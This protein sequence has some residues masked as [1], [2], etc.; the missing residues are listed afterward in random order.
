[1]VS[2]KTI[3]NVIYYVSI[4]VFIIF[5]IFIVKLPLACAACDED[6]VWYR[7]LSGGIGTST[8]ADSASALA[9]IK[10]IVQELLDIGVILPNMLLESV[11]YIKNKLVSLAQEIFDAIAYV[12]SGAYNGIAKVINDYIINPVVV[13]ADF[14]KTSIVLPLVQG[15]ATYIIQPIQSLVVQ[16][17][18]FKDTAFNA[19]KSAFSTVKGIAVDVWD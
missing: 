10:A 15:I 8:C 13:A 18:G 17:I 3:R 2:T 6:G 7:C 16:I 11:I 4:V 5:L 9:G 1:M 14:I 19:I 12:V